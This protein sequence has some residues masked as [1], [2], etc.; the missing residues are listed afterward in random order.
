MYTRKYIYFFDIFS[1]V[2]LIS[3]NKTSSLVGAGGGAGAAGSSSFLRDSLLMNFTSANT[4]NAM[5]M[6][7]IAVIQI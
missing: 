5:M 6:K 2:S 4:H 7:S 1:R 3:V